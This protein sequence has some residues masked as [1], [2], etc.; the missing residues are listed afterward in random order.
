MNIGIIT[1]W[2]ERG[3]AYVSKQYK[4]LLEDENSIYIYARRE[5]YAVGNPIWD[6]SNVTWGKRGK[7]YSKYRID[8]QKKD[9]LNWIKKNSIDVVFFNEQQCWLPVLW[10]KEIGVKVGS[11]IDYYTEETVPFFDIYDFLICNTERHYSVFKNH[12]NAIYIPWGTD[13]NLFKPGQKRE[14][15]KDKI[16]FFNSCGHNPYRKGVGALIKVF[17][18]LENKDIKLLVHTQK[19]LE[20]YYPELKDDILELE[21]NGKLEVITETVTA[22]GLYHYGDI[23]CYLSILDGIGLTLPEAISCG[24]PALIPD[25]APMNEFV[26]DVIGTKVKIER[27]YSRK[28]GYYWPQCMIDEDDLLLKVEEIIQNK[29]KIVELKKMARNYALENLNWSNRKN[30]LNLAFKNINRIERNLDLEKEILKFE[31]RKILSNPINLIG[32]PKETLAALKF[33]I[34]KIF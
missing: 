6:S 32:Y 16:V 3:A 4:E 24:L 8:I 28:D 25:N 34:G 7:L 15:D 19:R 33:Y 18:K 31:Y 10:C 5:D 2:F 29:E 14:E 26:D 9:F 17:K 27:L 21:K 30:E 12:K 11:Y 20:N 22:P 1:T 13:I 23:Y